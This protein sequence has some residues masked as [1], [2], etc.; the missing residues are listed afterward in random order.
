MQ[1]GTYME[2]LMRRTLAHA[3]LIVTERPGEREREVSSGR[4]DA[5]I[6]DYPYSRM[7][8]STDW[9]RRIEP[10]QTVQLTDYAYAVA[11][12]DAP[13]LARVQPVR[14]PDQGRRRCAARPKD[15]S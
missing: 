2:S 11:Q 15:I 5:F 4:A 7:L 13:W 8:A 6:T 12:G 9:A 10:T 14:H 3:R 1:K